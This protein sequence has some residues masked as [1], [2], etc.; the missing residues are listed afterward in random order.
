MLFVS[1]RII[2]DDVARLVALS[3]QVTG[4]TA[5]QGEVRAPVPRT[6]AAGRVTVRLPSTL[7][8]SHCPAVFQPT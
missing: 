3:E 2:T 1:I 7:T 6:D 5:G 8:P 4:A